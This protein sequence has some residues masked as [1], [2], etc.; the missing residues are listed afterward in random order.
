MAYI[1][2]YLKEKLTVEKLVFGNEFFAMTLGI[3]AVRG[4]RCALQMMGYQYLCPCIDMVTTVSFTQ[5][6]Q[7]QIHI[8]VLILSVTMQ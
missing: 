6:I 3:D 5:D 2:T 7:T 8:E 1:N 4:I